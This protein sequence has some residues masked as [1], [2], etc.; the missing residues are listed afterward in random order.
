MARRSDDNASTCSL[1]LGPSTST[2]AE[3]KANRLVITHRTC[4]SCLDSHPEHDTLELPCKGDDDVKP[5]AY[6]RECLEGFFES[7]VTDPSHFPP[8]CCSKMISLSSC[9]PFLSA[10]LIARFVARKEELETPNRTYCSNA[11]CSAWIRPAQILA[12]VAT[13]D[14]CAQQTCALCKSKAHI[15]H[16]CPE[17]QD[18]KELM[19]I[20]QHKRWQTCPNC[21]EM[22]ELE[23]G[24]FHIA[25]RCLYEFCYL[26]TAKWKRCDCPL[27]DERNLPASHRPFQ[28]LPLL[29]HRS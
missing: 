10:S 12:G 22:V 25:C 8:R 24:C 23:Q 11:E 17:D 19:I 15:G 1:T 26:C 7:S 29:L 5:H 14:Q 18:V 21:K 9:A 13:C 6:C 16:L 4:S 27:W 3:I 2:N 20:A 28:L